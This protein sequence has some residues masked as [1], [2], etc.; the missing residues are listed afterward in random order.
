MTFAKIAPWALA[1]AALAFAAM[2]FFTPFSGFEPDAF[3]IPQ[4]D[5]PAQPAGY[6]FAIWGL[7]YLWLIVSTL[8]GASARADDAGWARMRPALLVSLAIG[9]IW[10]PVAGRSPLWAL[11]LI[12]AMLITALI[13]L[14]RT[15]QDRDR[16]LLRAPIGLY[17]GWLTAASWVSVALNGAGFGV[18]MGETGWAIAAILGAAATALAVILR[19]PAV[20]AF[21]AAVVWAL[22]AVVVKWPPAPVLWL[23]V[24]A[25]LAVAAATARGMRRA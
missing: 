8:F 3:P 10:L 21:A 13:A 14:A 2:P 16:L 23:A 11:V 19:L 6:A 12:W 18:A 4:T 20:P 1:A 5:P 24:A 17:A 7:I 22:I 9:T 15:P 25:I